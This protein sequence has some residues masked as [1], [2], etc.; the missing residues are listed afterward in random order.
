M[1]KLRGKYVFNDMTTGRI[2]YAD[3]GELI[4]AHGQRNHQA[5]IHEIQLLYKSPTDTSDQSA[6][7]SRMYTIVAQTYA[8]KGGTP[9]ANQVLPGGGAATT[10]WRDPE[11]RQPKTDPEGVVYGGGRA[12]I[13]VVMGGDSELY[14][15]SKSDGMIRK[16]TSVV[17]PPPAAK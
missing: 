6:V 13:R 15:L 8:R 12:D 14:L 4:A 7:K 17:S 10:G 3:L 5:P 16:I 2:F 1:P 11:R 9:P